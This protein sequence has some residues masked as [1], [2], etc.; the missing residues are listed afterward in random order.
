[1]I[2]VA[3]ALRH[4]APAD[5]YG[6]L[7]SLATY[8]FLTACALVGLA[9]PA[10]LRREGVLTPL[11]AL[12]SGVGFIAMLL[13]IAGSVCP[14]PQGAYRWLPYIYL[15]YLIAGWLW[16]TTRRPGTGRRGVKAYPPEAQRILC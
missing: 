7:G 6:W 10:F 13:A 15:G 14:A 12:L 16:N 8:G 11:W 2:T 9:V 3:L 4:V 5:I 1:M